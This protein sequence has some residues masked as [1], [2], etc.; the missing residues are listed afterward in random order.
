MASGALAAGAGS[1]ETAMGGTSSSV[2][3]SASDAGYLRSIRSI[4]SAVMPSLSI[5]V[6]KSAKGLLTNSLSAVSGRKPILACPEMMKRSPVLTFTLSRSCTSTILKVPKAF[7]LTDFSSLI[8]LPRVSKN[9][10]TNASASLRCIPVRVA[11]SAARSCQFILF[12]VIPL[13]FSG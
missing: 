9:A 2:S 1:E 4:S 8:S 3:S 6:W 5:T 10:R 13:W 11:S 12:P 7:T